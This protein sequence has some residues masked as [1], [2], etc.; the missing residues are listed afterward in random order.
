MKTIVPLL[1]LCIS[2]NAQHSFRIDDIDQGYLVWEKMIYEDITA[3]ALE[4]A[5]L[6][7]GNFEDLIVLE[8]RVVATL[9][10]K[11]I[12]YSM[13]DALTKRTSAY[14]VSSNLTGIITIA[15]K[16]NGCHVQI[17]SLM[18]KDKAT[19]PS[20]M[21][22]EEE[23]RVYALRKNNAEFRPRFLKRDAAVFEHHLNGLLDFPNG[24][25]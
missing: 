21:V 4:S 20:L 17:H 18:L 5:M 15:I 24:F 16:E 11:A 25:R 6:S 12:D 2:L 22:E 13:T 19:N 10:E 14:I 3:K 1:F 23:L 9:K 7:S 8:N